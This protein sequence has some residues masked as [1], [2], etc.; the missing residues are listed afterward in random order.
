M[1]HNLSNLY[2]IPIQLSSCMC[3]WWSFI[4]EKNLLRIKLIIS[5][6]Y[7]LTYLVSPVG[8]ITINNTSC[9]PGVF[10]LTTLL[11]GVIQ[12]SSNAR[13]IFVSSEAHKSVTPQ[14]LLSF[15][16]H[17]S[18]PLPTFLD[19]VKIYGISKLA[20]HV[21]AQYITQSLPGNNYCQT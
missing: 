9:L 17:K 2:V 13:I 20:L 10:L 8:L 15:E 5:F 21:F 14:D 12:Q 18:R 11:Q 4:K 16:P 1:L 6:N 19:H 3:M 7:I